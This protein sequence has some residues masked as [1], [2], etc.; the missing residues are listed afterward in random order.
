MDFLLIL[1]TFLVC[2]NFIVSGL[3]RDM[4]DDDN[5]NNNNNNN[6]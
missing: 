3:T 4:N 6:N 5:N 2:F 1:K